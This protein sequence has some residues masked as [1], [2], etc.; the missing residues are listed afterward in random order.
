MRVCQFRHIRILVKEPAVL[1]FQPSLPCPSPR[2]GN[3][4]ALDYKTNL[5]PAHVRSGPDLIYALATDCNLRF[6][7]AASLILGLFGS[8]ESPNAQRLTHIQRLKSSCVQCNLLKDVER[9]TGLE[10][11][12]SSLGMWMAIENK[13]Q[14]RPCR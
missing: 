10:P 5:K 14:W 11:A 7:I 4:E 8:H 9:E 3:L 2:E 12:T 1:E 13:E 6:V